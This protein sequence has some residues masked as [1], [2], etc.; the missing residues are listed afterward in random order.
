MNND[1][2]DDDHRMLEQSEAWVRPEGSSVKGTVNFALARKSF[3]TVCLLI[4]LCL[5]INAWYP[6]HHHYLSVNL[7]L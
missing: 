5:Q 7:I 3:F 2:H 4:G 1:I 6:F